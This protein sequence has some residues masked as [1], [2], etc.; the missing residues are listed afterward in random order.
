MQ[1]TDQIIEAIRKLPKAEKDRVRKEA[2]QSDDDISASDE[3]IRL[4]EQVS[5]SLK[6]GRFLKPEL[7]REF[8]YSEDTP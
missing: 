3:S 7:D 4:L 2:F 5:G 8:L 6:V 1:T